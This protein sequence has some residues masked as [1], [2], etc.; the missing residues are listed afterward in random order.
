MKRKPKHLTHDE[1][2]VLLQKE[3][4]ERHK[5]KMPDLLPVKERYLPLLLDPPEDKNQY[6]NCRWSDKAK[7][8]L[9]DIDKEAQGKVV[10][11]K[12][13]I[14]HVRWNSDKKTRKY[15]RSF[16]YILPD[17]KN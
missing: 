15:H 3:S 7:E 10:W 12:D 17:E 13:D 9:K 1:W 14:V 16:I 5:K 8:Y 6:Q 4:K 11:I 2:L